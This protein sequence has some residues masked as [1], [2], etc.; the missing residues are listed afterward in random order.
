M[1]TDVRK[2][3]FG[4]Q[5]VRRQYLI[6]IGL[7]LIA[8]GVLATVDSPHPQSSPRWPTQDN[9]FAVDSWSMGTMH[10]ELTNSIEYIDRSYRSR[11]TGAEAVFSLATS[12]EA[13][14][15]YRAS[16]DVPFLGSGYSVESAPVELVPA[17]ANGGALLARRGDEIWLQIFA[18]GERRG[19]LGNGVAGWSAAL[20]D[21]T[22]AR[23]NDYYLAR[24]MAHMPSND[25]LGLAQE[26]SRLADILFT[27]V[28]AWYALT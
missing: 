13:K 27:R 2:S 28:P 4:M 19:T 26:A 23:G 24:L 10:T 21:A 3:G 22:L 20:L 14:R 1:R 17:R 8:G 5:A 11:A 16:A 25:N 18:Y 7:F 15:V 12:P 6:L 9:V